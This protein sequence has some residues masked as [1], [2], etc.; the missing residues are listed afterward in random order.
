MWSHCCLREAQSAVWTQLTLLSFQGKD[1]Q[2]LGSPQY[3][4]KCVTWCNGYD[5]IFITFIIVCLTVHIFICF[6]S[7]QLCS[8][9]FPALSGH[10]LHYCQVHVSSQSCGDFCTDGQVFTWGLDSRGQLGLGKRRPGASSPQH[11]RSLS[12]VPLVQISAGGEQSFAIS[13]SGGV[14]SWGRNDCG[15]LGLGDMT[16]RHTPTPVHCL[17]MKKT[18]HISCGKDHTAILT[19]DGAVFTFGSGQYGQLGH[20]SFT[21][22]LCP[23]LVAELLGAKVTKIAC[24][25]H[26]TLVLTDS[27]RVYS[28]GCGEQGQLGHGNESHPSVPLPVQ[29]PQD[30]DGPRIR[31]IFAGG[32]CSFATCTAIE[33]SA[34]IHK[35]ESG[36]VFFFC[37]LS[38]DK[39]FQTSPKYPGLNLS[40]ARLAFKKLI[41]R[42]DV[43]AEVC[44]RDLSNMSEMCMLL[45]KWL[46]IHLKMLVLLSYSICIIY[47]CH[48]FLFIL[49]GGILQQC[50]DDLTQLHMLT[51]GNCLVQPQ[52]DLLATEQFHRS[53]VGEDTQ[54]ARGPYSSCHCLYPFVFQVYFD[55]NPTVDNV[56]TKD[57]FHEVFH[58]MVSTESGMFMF[59]DSKTLAWFPSSATQEHQ[60]YFLFGV[61][62]GLA[63]YSQCIIYLPFPMVLFK[64]LLGVK[65]SLEDMM[66]FSPRLG[67]SLQYILED[68][69]DDDIENLDMKEFVDAYVNHAFNTSVESVFQ[70]FKRGFFHVCDQDVVRLFQPQELC[71]VLIGKDF[72]DWERLKQNTAYEGVY[73]VGHP[74]IQ[75]FWEVFD[76]LTED[77]KKTF[78][79]FVT[80]FERVPILGL[81]N[82]KMTVRVKEVQD[83][84]DDQ[85]YPETHTCFSCLELPLYSTKEIMQIKLTEALSNNRRIHK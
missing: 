67:K 1:K 29:L 9:L 69:N 71:E 16:D 22:E 12:A 62:C 14:F 8:F 6:H 38:K 37:L 73:H 66:E 26:H 34:L 81:E 27:K 13:V 65:P 70:E 83:L 20:N 51:P 39:H 82:I 61:L 43:L 49:I 18:I 53:S 64:K 58:E 68:Y 85:Y 28:F 31:N 4:T 50:P 63:L 55:E 45:L 30:S 47:I 57:F 15:Q 33:V 52:S 75:M 40:L 19:K 35:Y 59:N 21:D 42:D 2:C 36:L 44:N 74:T 11:L 46:N 24:G 23:R 84:T 54:G 5:L 32:N 17:N 7:S 3:A 41:K 76:D 80:G 60:R 72:H 48:I 25:R 78:L 77:Q 79:W 56:Y 10:R